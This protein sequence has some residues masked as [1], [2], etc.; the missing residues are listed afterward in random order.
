MHRAEVS[1]AAMGERERALVS[2][3]GDANPLKKE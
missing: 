1:G 3:S 2:A